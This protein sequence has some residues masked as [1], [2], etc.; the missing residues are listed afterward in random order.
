M[1]ARIGQSAA[2]VEDPPLLRG[3][4]RFVDDLPAPGALHAAFLR[5]PV[6]HGRIRAIDTAEARAMPGVAAVL[7]LA[8]LRAVLTA[9]RLP[10][11]F[12]N[13]GLPEGI[14][15]FVLAADE[16]L[17]V[18]ECVALVLADSRAAAEDAAAAIDLDIADLAP[19]AD[20]RAALAEG[21]PRVSLARDGNLYT[22]FRTAYGAADA[23][24][25]DAPCRI[26][27]SLDQ[28]RG[29]AHPMEGRGVLA[30]PDALRGGLTVWS[31]TQ[32]AH[33]AR[34]FLCRML[35]MDEDALR[36]VTPE[37]GGGFGAK[38]LLY[39]EEVAVAAAARL[40]G[41]TVKW[42]E[43]RREHFL[44][45]IQ[46][47]DQLWEIEVAA[48]ADGRLRAIR[49]AMVSDAGAYVPQGVNL[50]YNAATAVPG[51]YRLPHY[52]L[53]VQVCATNRPPTIPVR[54]AGYPEGTF[55]MERALDA[56]ADRLGL[57]RAEVR[58]RNLIA[59]AEM[60][61]ATPLRSRS[62]AGITY[63]SGDFPAMFDRALA[64]IDHAGFAERRR[65]AA[66]V[67]RHLG[68]GLA[69]GIKGTG[70]GPYESATV[71]IGRS[72]RVSVYT[73][74][75]QMGQGLRTILGQIAGE[76]LGVSEAAITVVSG[77]TTTIPLGL[78]GFASRQTVVAGSSVRLAA[79]RVRDQA[80][81]VASA[82]LEAAPDD[83][84]LADG[85]ARIKGSDRRVT[86]A[87]LADAA[88]GS[89]GY[90]LPPGVTPGLEAAES[91]MPGGLTYGMGA[92]AV[93]LEV[94]RD[95]GG[96]RLL[97]YVVVNDCG[98]AI[99]PRLVTGQL[100]GGVVHGI[101]N[102]LFERMVYD[103]QAQPTT[104]TLAEYLLPTAPEIPRIDCHI[105]E[106]PTPSNPLGVKGV[107]EAGTLPVAAAIVSAIEDAAGLP[108]G[109]IT[110]VPIAPPDLLALIRARG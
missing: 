78:G 45:A 22:A 26:A 106:Y 5:S 50:A 97:R 52:R 103:A 48:E 40:T 98:R 57:D 29:G 80:I 93:E 43:D 20:C 28:H 54:G 58:R 101:G 75:M 66:A 86:L 24:F 83:I 81:R 15:P 94:D 46:E 77:D 60:P 12:R 87:A 96:V 13:T 90:A 65:A 68:L 39:P 108:F 71:R 16:V 25:A 109:T 7:T 19:V 105:A 27:L 34:G 61:Y 74:A 104:T 51:P 37:V 2:R 85:H 84:E 110:R 72:G 30:M 63:D 23:A 55:A 92:H 64:M 49:G 36:V 70:R 99:N 73:G 4:A 31:S 88:A 17:F 53:D 100:H 3:T 79:E 82:L 6:A 35:G 95:T 9:D 38:Y 42:I 21:A 32:L 41:R 107:G 1:T 8:D 33:E 59:A 14:T 76:A 11:Q 10:L 62:G 18:G 56:V 102:A 67:G 91:W 44:A 89:P 47:R 69:C